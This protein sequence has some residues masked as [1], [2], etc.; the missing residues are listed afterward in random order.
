[1]KKRKSKKKSQTKKSKVMRRRRVKSR[2]K[3]V[4]PGRRRRA[5]SATKRKRKVKRRQAK[6]TSPKR[7]AKKSRAAVRYVIAVVRKSSPVIN[8]FGGVLN[9]KPVVSGLA[10]A[11]Q[12]GN[13]QAAKDLARTLIKLRQV[14]KVG[15]FRS[16]D[17]LDQMAREFVG[18]ESRR[19]K[20]K[21]R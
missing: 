20:R 2:K 11:L 1:M 16:S 9:K 3:L 10:G 17:S 21:K 18:A 5:G 12:F 4:A 7:T 8:F 13:L 19:V 6:R 14:K 15:I